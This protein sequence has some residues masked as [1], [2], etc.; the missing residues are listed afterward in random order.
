MNYAE[1]LRLAEQLRNTSVVEPRVLASHEAYLDAVD[2]EPASIPTR[3]GAAR[4]NLIIPRRIPA[5]QSLFVNVH[6]GGFVRPHARRDTVFCA[7]VAVRVGC[8]VLDLDYSLAPEHPFPAAFNEAYDVLK[9]AYTRGETIGVDRD[10][11]AM[12]GHSAGGN[13]TAGVAL[14]ANRTG[15]FA[16]RLQMLDYPFLDGVT[17]PADKAL[18]GD[19]IPVDRMRA[20]IE[21]YVEDPRDLANPCISPV[22]AEAASLAGLPPALVLTAGKDSLRAE[23]D[24]YVAM[25][26]AAGVEVTAKRFL[27]SDHGF[28]VN[29]L[30]EYGEAMDL[31]CDSLAWALRGKAKEGA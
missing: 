11:I 20:F 2:V 13:L 1:K 29:C 17:D 19:L 7:V 27:A 16:L 28:V 10:R 22:M 15:D 21:L 5:P 8:K 23:A 24:R 25:L 9:W 30:D 3:E 14:M 31:I 18:G 4:A 12:G 26:I 6:G